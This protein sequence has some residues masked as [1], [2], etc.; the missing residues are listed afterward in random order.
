[1][2]TLVRDFHHTL[3]WPIQLR[4][5]KRDAS[6]SITGGHFWD[7]LKDKPGAWKFVKDPL[8][9]DDESCLTGYEEFVYFLPYVQRFLYGVGEDGRGAQSSIYIFRRDDIKQVKLALHRDGP[10][11]TLEVLKVRLHFFYDA[12]TALLTFEVCGKD[13]PLEDASDIVDRFGRPYPPAW[14]EAAQ[15]AHCLEK[16][17]FIGSKG[18]ILHESDY[19]DWEKYINL[20]RD[21]RQTPLSSHWEWLMQ[22]LVPAYKRGGTI[23]F[24][25][26]ENKRIPLMSYMAFDDPHALSRGDMVRLGFAA[27]AGESESLP[28]SPKFLEDF[29]SKHC[30]DRYWDETQTHIN[31]NTRYMF[32]NV[33]FTMICKY[34]D[35]RTDLKQHFRHQF[36][37]IAIVAHF[38]KAALLNMSNRF[39]RAVERLNVRDIES[40]KVFKRD[41]RQTLEVFLRFNHRYWFQEISNQ[42]QAADFFSYLRTQLGSEALYAEVREETNDI[43]Q[44]LDNDRTR[45]QTDNA[46]RLTVVSICGMVGTIVTGF[47]GMNLYSHADFTPLTKLTIFLCVLLP[48]VTLAVVTITFSKRLADFME[49][50]SSEGLTW[51]E[52]LMTFKQIWRGNKGELQR[53]RQYGRGMSG[54]AGD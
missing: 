9:I 33:A 1:M 51:S 5:L 26:I 31:M 35:E 27:K 7:V 17:S 50:L 12:D 13:I 36:Y 34:Q 16:V 49:A 8:L 38:H 54:D 44:Y 21:A 29:E 10:A 24:Y 20:V 15:G 47:L 30:Y 2:T 23:K 40:V 4:P 48:A 25:Q 41:V 3:I 11:Y 19:E 39:S 45:K 6:V 37:Q 42:V 53:A 52:K 14:D 28:Y 46:M 18:E 43:N 32:C 22:P